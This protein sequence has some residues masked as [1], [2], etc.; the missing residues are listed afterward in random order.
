MKV[1]VITRHAV[2]N[3]GSLLQAI[4]TQRVLEDMGHNCLIVDYIRADESIL[5]IEPSLLKGK[6]NWNS[7]TIK[8]LLYL[9]LRQPESIAAGLSF[10]N[11]RNRYL[12]LTRR[13]TSF[14]E[15]CTDLPPADIYMTGS[16]QVWGP[17]VLDDCDRAYL[18]SFAPDNSKKIAYAASFGREVS[19]E[20]AE[21]VF[22]AELAEYSWLG[23]REDSAVKRIADWGYES[24]QVLDPTLL[25]DRREWDS[26]TSSKSIGDY[27]LVYQIHNNKLV[28]DCACDVS[29]RLGTKLVRVSPVLHQ[30]TR[31]GKFKYLPKVDEFLSLIKKAKCVVTDS[32]HGTVFSLLFNVPFVEILPANGTSERNESLLRMTGLSHRAVRSPA[33]FA[34]AEDPIDFSNANEIISK[35]RYHSIAFLQAELCS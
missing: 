5:K 17:M 15:L 21:K 2:A 7:S 3:Y 12:N 26:F 14:E 8:R 22:C 6:Q 13:Y 27:V 9:A 29:K 16:D 25:L 31:P 10:A 28:D 34:I 33:N 24:T 30:I 32:F 19:S 4:A 18:L 35:Q 1:L 20:E 23:V 11:E